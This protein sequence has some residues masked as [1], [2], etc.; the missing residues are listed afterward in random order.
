MLQKGILL[1]VMDKVTI[2]TGRFKQWTCQSSGLS[3]QLNTLDLVE[4][5]L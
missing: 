2:C 5:A 4:Y 1:N 3:A